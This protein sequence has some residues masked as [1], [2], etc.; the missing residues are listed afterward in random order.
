LITLINGE[1]LTPDWIN[2]TD[3]EILNT[4]KV[5]IESVTNFTF[6]IEQ[7]G[8]E[9][10]ITPDGF[11]FGPKEFSW[12]IH[13]DDGFVNEDMIEAIQEVFFNLHISYKEVR[14][15]VETYP[16]NTESAIPENLVLLPSLGEAMIEFWGDRKAKYQQTDV[17]DLL[18]IFND[19]LVKQ[20]NS[21][22]AGLVMNLYSINGTQSESSNELIPTLTGEFVLKIVIIDVLNLPDTPDERLNAFYDFI[23]GLGFTQFNSIWLRTSSE[24]FVI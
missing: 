11:R 22:S 23:Q 3:E 9:F 13:T 6:I 15:Y 2:K 7:A 21:A 1:E 19:E 10:N 18:V 5:A 20:T 12:I 17:R 4:A 16:S 8:S 14:V 24:R